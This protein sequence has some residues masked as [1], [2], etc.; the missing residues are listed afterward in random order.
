MQ[1][2]KSVICILICVCF[3]ILAAIF[4]SVN[5]HFNP[6]EANNYSLSDTEKT[7]ITLQSS[8]YNIDSISEATTTDKTTDMQIQFS[9]ETTNSSQQTIN[10]V[11]SELKQTTVP[12]TTKPQQTT[13]VATTSVTATTTKEVVTETASSD[14]STNT[15]YSD[16]ISKVHSL[17]NEERQKVGLNSLSLSGELNS[18]ALIRAKETTVS[19]SHTRPDGTSCFTVLS[20]NNITYSAC[21][22]NI[23][24]G[25]KTP[26]EVME[27]WMNSQGHK[28]NILNSSFTNVGIGVYEKNGTLY[29]VQM[30]TK[31]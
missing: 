5:S 6:V 10:S 3:S 11:T 4:I 8:D 31:N 22:E 21:G 29:W 17:I 16:Y 18:A 27:D 28:D 2:K 12:E 14:N 26:A 13:T 30:F 23:A 1:K 20:E 9:T 19:F 25:Q 24:M 7:D 15:G